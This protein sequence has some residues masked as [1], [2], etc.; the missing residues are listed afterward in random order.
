M[1]LSCEVEGCGFKT[2]PH[3]KYAKQELGRH[4]K[5]THGISGKS[6]S[7]ITMQAKKAD[8]AF[9]AANEVVSNSVKVAMTPLSEEEKDASTKAAKASTQ[10]RSY[11]KAIREDDAKV[12]IFIGKLIALCEQEAERIGSPKRQFAER[13]AALFYASQ[14][15]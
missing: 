12:L 15:G 14:V 8:A 5:F 7:A 3:S 2:K 6:S 13:C 10:K 1:A 4:M 9:D 11:N